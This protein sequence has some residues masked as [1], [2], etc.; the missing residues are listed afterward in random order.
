MFD[1][2]LVGP[3]GTVVKVTTLQ[4]Y[5]VDKF[6][7]LD[8]DNVDTS[9]H[10]VVFVARGECGRHAETIASMPTPLAHLTIPVTLLNISVAP[11]PDQT[12]SAREPDQP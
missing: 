3:I 11:R 10:N 6:F 4:E 12:S 9:Q 1:R 7:I 2:S 8:N 5:G